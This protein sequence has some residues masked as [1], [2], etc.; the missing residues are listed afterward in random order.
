[1]HDLFLTECFGLLIICVEITH[2]AS[3]YLLIVYDA[4][5]VQYQQNLFDI[6]GILCETCVLVAAHIHDIV[7]QKLDVRLT[8][9][10]RTVISGRLA[11]Q[12]LV[13]NRR[14]SKERQTWRWVYADKYIDMAL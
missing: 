11:C 3:Y 12:T 10:F 5:F 7:Q 13:P 14:Y 9:L 1:M 4:L 6:T 2:L 8:T